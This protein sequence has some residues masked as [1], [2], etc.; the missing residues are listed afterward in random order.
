MITPEFHNVFPI[1]DCEKALAPLIRMW[2]LAP[3]IAII[4]MT[5]RVRV[6]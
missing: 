2:E 5:I 3:L 1:D 6:R 4:L